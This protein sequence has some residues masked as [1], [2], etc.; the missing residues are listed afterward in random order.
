MQRCSPGTLCARST[1]RATPRAEERTEVHRC[2][3]DRDRTLVLSCSKVPGGVLLRRLYFRDG[4][5]SAFSTANPHASHRGTASAPAPSMRTRARTQDGSQGA[6]RAN[7]QTLL[8]GRHKKLLAGRFKT[9]QAGRYNRCAFVNCRRRATKAL[10]L[11]FAM[12]SLILRRPKAIDG[13]RN[14]S[15]AAPA[16]KRERYAASQDDP[17]CRRQ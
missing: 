13:P 1:D 12:M 10:G 7:H 3:H 8:T 15:R 6:D 4:E 14:N 16:K 2:C 5:A 11:N 9:L 17:L